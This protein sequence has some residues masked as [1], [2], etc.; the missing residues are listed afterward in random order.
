MKIKVQ[1]L[2]IN[3]SDLYNYDD[4]NLRD[5]YCLNLLYRPCKVF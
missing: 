2:H 3:G 4:N 5:R 1:S